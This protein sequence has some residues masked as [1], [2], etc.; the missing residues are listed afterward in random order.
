MKRA[1]ILVALMVALAGCIPQFTSGTLTIAATGAQT[2]TVTFQPPA[3]TYDV[4]LFI[5]DAQRIL[6][7]APEL[8]CTA[9]EMGWQCLADTLDAP[10]A[11]TVFADPL[12]MASAQVWW[13]VPGRSVNIARAAL[14]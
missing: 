5:G 11:V 8:T 6:S 1:L 7:H 12:D 3:G 14:K 10:V 4:V 9:F 13:S 2:A